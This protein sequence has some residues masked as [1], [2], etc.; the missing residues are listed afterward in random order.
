MR[1]VCHRGRRDIS[2]KILFYILCASLWVLKG[3]AAD[4]DNCLLEKYKNYTQAQEEWQRNITALIVKHD[5]SFEGVATL[6]MQ[7]QLVKIEKNLRAVEI[8]L[9]SNSGKID[10]QRKLNQWLDL[11]AQ[12]EQA[13]AKKDGK[14]AELL[15]RANKSKQRAP[16]PD[17]DRL[18]AAMRTKIAPLPQFRNLFSTF[19]GEIKGLESRPC[20]NPDEGKTPIK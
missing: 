1:P 19:T 9:L 16:H 17:G 7:D 5:P 4:F 18:R 11:K 20:V 12:D 15:L 10:G 8:L 6:Y 3:N 13:F 14:Y 2:M